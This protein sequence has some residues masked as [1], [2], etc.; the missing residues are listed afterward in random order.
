MQPT[1]LIR[2]LALPTAATLL[3]AA[4]GTGGGAISPGPSPSPGAGTVSVRVV[5]NRGAPLPASGFAYQD[6]DGA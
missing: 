2:H 3:L 5:D 6:G 1:A 4:C